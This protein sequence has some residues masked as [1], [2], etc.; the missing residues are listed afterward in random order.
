MSP[1][2]GGGPSRWPPCS[3]NKT[4]EEAGQETFIGRGDRVLVIVDV[5]LEAALSFHP[6][7]R[8]A[9]RKE[10]EEAPHLAPRKL[11]LQV[12]SGLLCVSSSGCPGSRF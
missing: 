6:G 9:G 12:K 5:A 10:E 3:R 7:L 8:G 4:L 1:L 11:P 2:A